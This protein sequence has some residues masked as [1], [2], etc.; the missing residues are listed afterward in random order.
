MKR[1]FEGLNLAEQAGEEV[2]DGL[3]LV[4]VSRA[5]YDGMLVNPTTR[6]G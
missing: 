3:L 4:Q 5:Q 1:R 6:C 2:P